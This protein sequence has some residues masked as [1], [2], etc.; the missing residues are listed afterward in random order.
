MESS[1]TSSETTSL[2]DFRP[3][4]LCGI[5]KLEKDALMRKLWDAFPNSFSAAVSHTAGGEF[6]RGTPYDITTDE[7]QK[8]VVEGKFA[9]HYKFG[10]NLCGISKHTISAVTAAH[11]IAVLDLDMQGVQ[12]LK[13]IPEFNARYIFIMPPNPRLA[14]ARLTPQHVE[15]GELQISEPLRR[16]LA[17]FGYIRCPEQNRAELEYARIPGVY[18]LVLSSDDLDG[19]FQSLMDFIIGSK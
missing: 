18:D 11:R 6:H 13:A 17:G 10:E 16:S 8:M 9:A 19:A 14:E 2:R 1:T 12:Q 5:P 3:L 4:V 7:F 15:P